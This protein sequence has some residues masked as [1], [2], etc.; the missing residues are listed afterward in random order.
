M[1]ADFEAPIAAFEDTNESGTLYV[2]FDG[3]L[4]EVGLDHSPLR[5]ATSAAYQRL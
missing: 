1:G 3:R 4:F 5:E 2:K